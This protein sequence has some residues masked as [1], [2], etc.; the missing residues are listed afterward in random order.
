MNRRHFLSRMALAGGAS[1]MGMPRVFAAPAEYTGRL[2]VVLQ[3][4]GG[5][6]VTSYCDP[7]ENQP[8]E[9]E[10]T[11]WS[12]TQQTQTAGSIAYAPYANNAWFF[13]KYRNDMLVINGVDAQTNSHTTGVL[14]NWSGRNARGFPSLTAL[15]SA[16]QAPEIP[17][18]YINFGGFGDTANLIRFSRLDNVSAL[19][20]LLTPEQSPWNEAV[21]DRR[22]DDMAR[23]RQFR[24]DRNARLM[25]DAGNLPRVRDNLIAYD[26]ALA[27]KS[28]LSRFSDFVPADS[29]VLEDVTVNSEVTSN[30]PRQVQLAI[31]TFE[32]G[33]GCAADLNLGGYDTHQNHDSLHEP[34]IGHLNDSI[35]LLWTL[36]EARGLADRLTVVIGSDFGRTP[37]YNA[38]NGKDHWPIGSFI[39]MERGAAWGNR[40]VG[41][42]DEGHN[43]HYINPASLQR[44]D[45]GGTI[46]YPKHVHKALRR[47]LGMEGSLVESGF[48]FTS[49]EDFDFF[50]PTLTT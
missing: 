34:L 31:A 11:F 23:I 2:L 20:E 44:D 3:A 15:F 5:W 18:S 30:M 40:T 22:P 25:A 7:K 12:R 10:I 21:T 28:E 38:D 47:H 16:N 49:A 39:V 8:G 32:A 13:D 24:R 37:R 14:H 9:D 41:V 45:A 4:E 27:S 17:L 26:S 43:A 48:Q 1:V 50:N 46:I 42:T 36:A 19:R 35:D 33:I 29:E 6:D